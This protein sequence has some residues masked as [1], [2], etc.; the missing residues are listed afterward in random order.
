M[1]CKT[2]IHGRNFIR[3]SLLSVAVALFALATANPLHADTI[4]YDVTLTPNAGNAYGGSGVL[5][6]NGAAPAASGVTDYTVA[7]GGLQNVTFSIDGQTFN[8]AGATGNTLVEFTNGV[9]T[10]ITF[11]EQIGNNP[12]AGDRFALD[13]TGDYVFY[14]DNEGAES[15]GTFTATLVSSAS[16]VPE[17]SSLALFGTGLLGVA[18]IVRRRVFRG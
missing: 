15:V 9:L 3:L 6:L 12:Y 14:Y 10:D 18:G 1:S 4:T 7:N 16:P 8:L 13:T 17:P 11:A 5:T 2:L